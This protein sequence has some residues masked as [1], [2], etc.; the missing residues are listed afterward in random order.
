MSTPGKTRVAIVFGGRSP[1]H[2]ISCVSAGS[3]LAAL[4][5]DEFEVVPVG[6]TRQGQWVLA[7]GDPGQLAIA[8]R[9][10]PEITAGSGAEL[11]LRADPAVGGLMV[12]DPTQGPVALADVDV[13][14]P[15][16]H[17]AYGEDGTIQGMLEMADIPYVGAN[18]FASAAAM[19]KEFTKKLCAAEGIPVGPYVVL[20]AG[21]TL[22]E[23]DKAR[24]GLPVFVK[25][26]RAGSSFGITKVDDWAQL[27]AAVATAREIDTKV[28]VEG[29]IVG[30]EI[31]C[32]VL[33][34]EAGG[35]PEASVLAEV[36]VVSG[37]DWYDF[38]AKYI[39][40][41]CEYDIPANLPEPVTRQVR[42]YATRAFTA[43]DC[44]G[45]ARADFFVTPE[46]DVYLNEI[47]T[48]PGFTPTSMFPRMW[49]ASGLEYPKLVNRLIRTALRRAGR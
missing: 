21:M 29:A 44:S 19:D 35:A 47:N 2:G 26:S 9:K 38:E 5:P 6:I 25:P 7:S 49:A 24:L 11:V 1:E 8:D 4:D 15:V 43:L 34:G 12:L 16:L 31:E 28:L 22:T 17:G 30:R 20:R 18:V 13:V 39:D 23:E 3:V 33:E 10:L 42:E 14:F 40:D 27:D 46:L 45:L 37:H 48:M 32:G 41:A 36:R